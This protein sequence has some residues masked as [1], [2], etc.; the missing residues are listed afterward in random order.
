MLTEREIVLTPAGLKKVEAE[1]ERLQTKQRVEVAGRIRESKQYGDVSEIGGNS[2]Y[3]EAK[4]EQAFVEGQILELKKILSSARVVNLEDVPTD[5]V[6][7]GTVVTVRD[8]ETHEEWPYHIVGPV[9]ADPDEDRI[10]Y[11]SPVGG[12]LLGARVGDIVEVMAPAGI[13]RYK[14]LNISK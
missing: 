12:G 14:I 11:E 7:I 6:G 2:E 4:Q 3:E 9:E 5:I 8:L 13:L 10:S 1:L